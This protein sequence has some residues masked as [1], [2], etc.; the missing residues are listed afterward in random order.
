M[1]KF[2]VLTL[3]VGTVAMVL[4]AVTSASAQESVCGG[5]K[6]DFEDLPATIMGVVI[7]VVDDNTVHFDIPEGSTVVVCVKAGSDEQGN[8]PEETILTADADL[9]HSSGKD[10]SHVA[11]I[12]VTTTTSSSPPPPPPSTSTPPP[13]P[14]STSTHRGRAAS[15]RARASV[16]SGRLTANRRGLTPI[17]SSTSSD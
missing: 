3:M 11:V 7:T 15:L 16:E 5:T 8:G 1:K 12:S 17:G 4:G 14:P 10:I 2:A 13:P 6:V 9:D